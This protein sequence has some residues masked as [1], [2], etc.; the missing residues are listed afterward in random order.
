MSVFASISMRLICKDIACNSGLRPI[1]TKKFVECG[2]EIR[3][4][5]K[6]LVWQPTMG[7]VPIS[8]HKSAY[9]T[10][11]TQ[12]P[13]MFRLILTLTLLAAPA[14]ADES[15][16]YDEV[17]NADPGTRLA[18]L[19]TGCTTAVTDPAAVTAILTAAN[20]TRADEFDGTAAFQTAQTDMMFYQDAGFCMVSV[21]DFNTETLTAEL[22][23]QG[24]S[25]SGQDDAG[26]SQFDL[27]GTTA[28]LTGGG[29]DPACTS[30]TE[31]VLRFEP[32]Q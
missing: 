28:T 32:A 14:F 23:D 5:G 27:Q 11:P 10:T 16:W 15:P 12:G 25:S 22:A 30:T 7:N 26:C 13:A 21:T 6:G 18:A 2:A 29:N 19:I 31:A 20:W 3:E 1:A 17:T 8:S 24:I 4:V 9:Q